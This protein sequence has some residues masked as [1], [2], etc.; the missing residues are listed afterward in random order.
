ML[1]FLDILGF[2]LE[3]LWQNRALVFWALIGLAAATTLTLSIVLYVDAVNSDLLTSRLATPPFGFR[4][5]YLGSWEG[6]IDRESFERTD[7]TTT[8]FITTIGLPVSRQ[9]TFVRGATLRFSS[10]LANNS[11]IV[12]GSFS[13]GMV[14]GNDD[15][16]QIV[17]G[18]WTG[19]TDESSSATDQVIPVLLS[20]NL[21]YQMGLQVGD[22]LTAAVPGGATLTFQ[23]AALWEP[24]NSDDP[25]WIFPP[26]FFE[27]VF[28]VQPDVFWSVMNEVTDPIQE[29]AWGLIFDGT[30]VR[31]SD[32]GV[33]LGNIETGERLLAN[34]LPGIRLDVTPTTGLQQFTDEVN[35][36][37]QQLFLVILPVGG[38]V[39]YFVS[40]VAGLLVSRQRGEDAVLA[41]RGMKR[42]SLLG[43]HV[44]MWLL[45][46]GSAL[47]I[48]LAL[49][50]IVVRLIG[51]TTSFL[52]FDPTLPLLEITLT[53]QALL[54]GGLT[55][56]IAASSGLF[57]AWHST[58]QNVTSYTRQAARSAQA[59]WQRSY[60]DLMALV[61]GVYVLYT[62][63]QRGG[64]T[65][66]ADNPFSDPLIFLGPTLFAL[67]TT[68]LF[69]RIWPFLLRVGAGIMHYTTS[70]AILMALRELTRSIGRYRGT[71]LM[72][73]FTLSLT[74][75]T[76]SMAST[77]DRSL[78]DSVN[79][80]IGADAVIVTTVDAE[81]EQD[82]TTDTTQTT[83]T[84]TGYNILPVDDLREIEGVEQVARVGRYSGGI[85]LQ[86][87]RITGTIIGVDRAAMAAVTLARAD[88]ADQSYA[89][90][91]NL[92]ANNRSGVILTRQTA[93]ENNILINQRIT[94][95]VSSL[96]T[97]YETEVVV[98]GLIDYFPTMDPN[99]GFFLITNL[100]PIF[101]LVGTPLPHDIWLNLTPDADLATI[102]AKVIALGFPVV[103][104]QN[105]AA[106][107]A[108]AQAEPARRGVL[109]FLSVGFVA[110]ILLTLVATIIQNTVSFRAQ[111]IQL[112]ALR[113]LG[114]HGLAVSFYMILL[115]GISATS[116][117][118][119]GTAIGVFTTLLFL[120]FLDFSGGLPPYLV[121]VAWDDIILV[122]GIFA[123]ILISITLLTTLLMG[124]EQ[125]S[126]VVKL[127]DV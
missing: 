53:E 34:V 56:L 14:Q 35:R 71:L 117:I 106:A 38:L 120:P 42:R 10:T 90:L 25:A 107:L 74:G 102:Q 77:I 69:L 5:R 11:P 13:L 94:M 62:L 114:L 39:F 58:R 115:Q 30:S 99:A 93:T 43:V 8:Q 84:V 76:A 54:I 29:A 16:I 113:A 49:A 40:L 47:G 12:F 126:T 80:S 78:E 48:G 50:P 122:Y 57:L 127:G 27:E 85:T 64:L 1:H 119:G 52:R 124:R 68:L 97:T 9:T 7:A 101:E 105:P 23:V 19:E 73:C 104:W 75:I 61:P 26:R 67:G 31:T 89:D 100:E 82:S 18:E 98:V 111:K 60:L 33:V 4:F 3:R 96:D 91:F 121:R 88:Y 41:S 20:Q 59:W 72:I 46:A 112:G 44:L 110:S 37:T 63:W 116:G 109:G 118:M 66:S 83:V 79:Y 21:L 22:Q 95:T 86:S 32:V 108:S 125:L 6:N 51:Q 87:R 36:L 28:L 24:V 65:T 55:A 17:N 123:A 45:L 103:E 70:V 81:T 15:L 92:L 2:A